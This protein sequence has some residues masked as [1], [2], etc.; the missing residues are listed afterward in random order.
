MDFWPIVPYLPLIV[1]IEKSTK[2]LLTGKNVN[3]DFNFKTGI[4]NFLTDETGFGTDSSGMEIPTAS[5]K[6]LIGSAKWDMT[7]KTILMKGFGETSS[8]T[9]MAPGTGRIDFQ[10][11]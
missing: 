6:T 5:Y 4:A 10:W 11:F 8:Y 1:W 7:K 3:I 9:S 2:K